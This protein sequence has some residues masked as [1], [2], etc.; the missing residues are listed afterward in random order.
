MYPAWGGQPRGDPACGRLGYLAC[1]PTCS[2]AYAVH[3][4]ER[5]GFIRQVWIANTAEETIEGWILSWELTDD[6][7]VAGPWS[8][9]VA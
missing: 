9:T 8:G 7:E 5:T 3:G 2:V 1:R 4:P 6:E